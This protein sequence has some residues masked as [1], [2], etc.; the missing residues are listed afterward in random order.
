MSCW[1][2][3]AVDLHLSDLSLAPLDKE[4]D[5][6]DGCDLRPTGKNDDTWRSCQ[7]AP[8]QPGL[9]FQESESGSRVGEA[10]SPSPR[11]LQPWQGQPPTSTVYPHLSKAAPA[12]MGCGVCRIGGRWPAFSAF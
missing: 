8:G 12:Q 10:P 9:S 6:Q 7:V 4:L 2:G 11:P 5:E 1:T 3:S